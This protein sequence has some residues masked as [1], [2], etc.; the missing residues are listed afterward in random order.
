VQFFGNNQI[1]LFVVGLNDPVNVA[2]FRDN[3]VPAIQ[4]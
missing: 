3:N 4:V 2:A 1:D